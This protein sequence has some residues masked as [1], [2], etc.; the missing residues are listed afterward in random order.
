MGSCGSGGGVVGVRM[1]CFEQFFADEAYAVRV[2][3]VQEG[4]FAAFVP[5]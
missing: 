1:Q 2:H 5:P 3:L 4:E